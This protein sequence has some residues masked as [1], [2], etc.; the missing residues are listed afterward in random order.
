MYILTGSASYVTGSNT[1]KVGVVNRQG[2]FRINGNV[3]AD[4]VQRYRNGVPDSVIVYN[5]PVRT[6]EE[7]NADLGIYVQDSWTF[8]RLTLNPGVR[9]EYFNASINAMEVEA[10]RFVPA[11]SFPEQ[12]DL[13]RWF[14][15]A[16]RFGA[17]YD[18][19]GDAKTA[20]R[21]GVNRYNVSYA[22]NATSPYDPLVIKSDTRNWSDC[23]YIPRTSTCSTNVLPTN[24][25]NIAQDNEIGPVVTPFGLNR[26]QDPNKKRD[27]NLQYNIGV[28]R[29]VFD[30]VSVSF[31]WFKRTWYDMPI[32][33]NELVDPVADYTAFQTTNPL[34]GQAM[35]LYNLNPAK[36]GQARLLDTT[37]VDRSKTSKGYTGLELSFNARLPRG[38]TVMAGMLM[39]RTINVTCEQ[40]DPNQLYNCDQRQFD[41]PFR[42]D[43]KVVGTYPVLFGVQLGAVLQ[44]YAGSESPAR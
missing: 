21:V 24:R 34:T 12:K 17:V 38:A 19:T 16:P 9:F 23:D 33:Q 39:D 29:Q 30:G 18:L 26:F 4:L 6:K 32:T 14:D 8:K 43:V 42:R 37:S 5:T 35:T 3:N 25:D 22:N 1:L 13:P 36:A 41:V 7:I 31:A 27:F 20:I 10:G 11:R 2:P 28:D 15:V 40:Q 44:S